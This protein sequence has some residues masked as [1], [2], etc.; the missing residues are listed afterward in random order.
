M[1][2]FFSEE[3]LALF[4]TDGLLYVNA[5]AIWTPNE[6]E[7]LLEQ[8]LLIEALEDK[9]LMRYFETTQSVNGEERKV[10]Q[11]I[12]NFIDLSACATLRDLMTGPLFLSRVSALFNAIQPVKSS[13]LLHKEK[14]NYKLPGGSG[15]KPHQD[16][17]A[18]WWQYGQ[19]LHISAYVSIDYVNNNNGAL[20]LVKGEHRRGLIGSPFQELPVDYCAQQT[21]HMYE[22]APGDVLF[23]TSFVPHRS[24]P[25]HT[26]KSRRILY[27]TYSMAHEG[28]F[29]EQ[30]FAD[31]RLSYPPDNERFSD[32]IYE[33]KI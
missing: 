30:Y 33:Y 8:S 28:N 21:W 29:R 7:Q 4:K 25:N 16:A 14:I 23:F 24:G 3:Q 12:E 2:S 27:A 17:A 9:Q 5:N 32:Q 6:L 15:Y 13:A 1:N 26:N 19:T 31:K 18:G 11:R 10:L 22:T 20:E